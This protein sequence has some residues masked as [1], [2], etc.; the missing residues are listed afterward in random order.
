MLKLKLRYFV[1]LMWRTYS[2]EKT[3]MLG[4]VKG[5]R[6]RKWQ[7][8][9]WLD[10]ITDMMDMILSK[11]QVLVMDK[12][13]WCTAV[14]GVANSQTRLCD[15]TELNWYSGG[16]SGGASGKNKKQKI[17]NLPA[18]AG[19]R[20]DVALI[21]RSGRSPGGGHGSP[22]Q[23]SFL[24]NSMDRVTQSQTWLKQLSTHASLRVLPTW[25]YLLDMIRRT[26][27][28]LGE[29]KKNYFLELELYAVQCPGVNCTVG[30]FTNGY[31]MSPMAQLR[32]KTLSLSQKVLLCPFHST[33]PDDQRQLPFSF[34]SS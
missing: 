29:K 1:H 17:K 8:M 15:Q 28:T 33:S 31:T 30:C 2:F 9:R 6:R 4:K 5:G 24:E 32:Q 22:L 10:G 23:Y 12:E 21:P 20:R 16:F 26:E 14:H 3:L 34:P 13:A 27:R 18:N 7:K 11:L 19:D 25:E